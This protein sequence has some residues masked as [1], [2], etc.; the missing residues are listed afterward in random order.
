MQDRTSVLF[1]LVLALGSLS[2]G[3]SRPRTATAAALETIRPDAIRAHVRFLADDLLE[4]RGTGTRGYQL[5][6]NYVAAQL[7]AVG[8]E[9]AGNDGTYFQPVAFRKADLVPGESSLT[10]YREGVARRL[11]HGEHYLLSANLVRERS[12]VRAPLVFVGFGVTAPELDHDDY[13]GIDAA[14]KIAVL[15]SGAPARFPHNERAYFSSSRLKLENAASHGA[16]GVLTVQSAVDRRRRP[17][18][19][20]VRRSGFASMR[21]L[22][23]DNEPV[24]VANA[25]RAAAQ[26]SLDG[27]EAVFEG[28]PQ[29]LEDVLSR[30]GNGGPQPF[31]LAFEAE[32]DVA[33]RHERVESPNVIGQRRGSDPELRDEY[34]VYSAH[35]DHVGIGEPVDGDAIYNGAMDNAV[36]VAVMIEIAR[37]FATLEEPPRRSVLFLAVTGEEKGLLGSD[38]FMSRP[39][40]PREQIVAN[41]NLDAGPVMHA[42]HEIIPTGAEHSSLAVVVERVAAQMDLR[43]SPDPEPEEV[44][45]IR[46]DQY[47]F[48]RWGVPAVFMNL[49]LETGEPDRDGAAL[50][51]EW[52]RTRYHQPADDLNQPMDLDAA[53][54][55]ANTNFLLG[56]HVASDADRPTWNP[57]DFFGEKFGS[58]Q[59][60]ADALPLSQGHSHPGRGSAVQ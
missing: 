46:S 20:L 35:L 54:L 1:V 26:L 4:G 52:R 10:L 42:L 30:A 22:N 57:G 49:G 6:A 56:F 24:G 40:V 3:S 51:D 15:L 36:W 32:L 43:V 7:E 19:A 59:K 16:V 34:V 29:R 18:P 25:I 33:T 47:S 38:Y 2:C 58:P 37:A 48:V 23:E 55:F 31:D 21:W 5:A 45:F 13:A 41:L 14:G 8:L 17:W 53:A 60:G 39:T 12:R 11:E 50:K 28:A 27:A 9:P 44:L